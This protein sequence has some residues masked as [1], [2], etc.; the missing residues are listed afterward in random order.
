MT[1]EWK[2]GI[3]CAVVGGTVFTVVTQKDA[4]FGV[5]SVA[6]V[7]II[8]S[9][10]ICFICFQLGFLLRRFKEQSSAIDADTNKNV[11]VQVAGHLSQ[12]HKLGN[13]FGTI[14]L[15]VKTALQDRIKK[16]AESRQLVNE[17][18]EEASEIDIAATASIDYSI[19]INKTYG[20]VRQHLDI[21]ISAVSEA[22]QWSKQLVVEAQVFKE[23]FTKINVIADTIFDISANTN[24]LALNAAIEAARAGEAGR[25]FAVVADEVK[26]LAQISGENAV[27]I[28]EQI[29]NVARMEESMHKNTAAF[30]DTIAGVINMTNRSEKGLKD[31]AVKLE[32]HIDEIENQINHIK[33]KTADQKYRLNEIVNRLGDIEERAKAATSGSEKSIGISENILVEIAQLKNILERL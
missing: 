28:N 26:K 11:L 15:N 21:L 20:G 1:I 12:L 33:T 3:L 31:I 2:A 30:S 7:P 6:L 13:D 5:A 19:A 29:K 8:L 18:V 16:L 4:L 9:I 25:G 22:D 17:I 32:N 10:A 27:K 24:L 14:A 23:E